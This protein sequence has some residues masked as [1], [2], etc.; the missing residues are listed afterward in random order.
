VVCDSAV[1]GSEVE[2]LGAKGA[3]LCLGHVDSSEVDLGGREILEDDVFEAG[4]RGERDL[5]ADVGTAKGVA[6]S[7]AGLD[8]GG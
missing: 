7:N 5:G 2:E 6:A 1:I 4:V 8:H 3:A